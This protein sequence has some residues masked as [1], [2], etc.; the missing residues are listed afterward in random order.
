LGVTVAAVA[1]GKVHTAVLLHGATWPE[2][3]VGEVIASSLMSLLVEV[4]PPGPVPPGLVIRFEPTMVV[5][6]SGVPR[7]AGGTAVRVTLR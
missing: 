5:C 7:A 4:P 3:S 2:W 6:V 1:V